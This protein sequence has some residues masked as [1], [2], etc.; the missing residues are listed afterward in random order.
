MSPE[1]PGPGDATLIHPPRELYPTLD[2]TREPVD[3]ALFQ[4]LPLDLMLR[5]HF[6]PV[7]EKEGVLWIA[8][9]D[10]L[11]IHAQDLLRMQLKRPLKICGAPQAQIQEVLKKSESGQKVLDEA[12]EAL[13]VQVLREEDLDEEVLDLERLTDKDE[14]PIIRLVDTTIFNALQRRASDIHMET[15]GAGFQIKYRID[16]SLYPAADP[17]DKRFASPIV[18]RIKVMSEL[19]IAEKRKPQDGRFTLKVRGRAIDFRVSIMPTIHGEDAVIRILDKENLSEEFSKLSLDILGF[20]Q[21]EL[22]KLRRFAKEPYGMFLVTGPTGSGKT[23]T[24]YAILSEIRNPEDKIITIE[25]PVEYQLEGVTQIPVNE[26]KGL[27]FALG[28]RSILR[29]DPD[30][31]LVGEIRDPETAQI[32]IQSALT[33][34]LVFTTVHANN[35]FDVLGRF[36]H[37]GVPIHNFVSALNCVLAQR[38]VKV[39]CP[40]CKKPHTPSAQEL[41]ENGMDLAWARSGTFFEK[42]G[43][44]DCQGNGFRGRQAIIEFLG[45]N[46][47]M[48]ELM[49]AQAG[50]REV[51]AAARRAGMQSLRESAL[52]KVR[53][54]MTTFAEINKVTFRE[55][56]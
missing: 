45:M 26:K 15:T 8:M 4:A 48:R 5:L 29:H 51:K 43:C 54:G 56:A 17:I 16:G 31:I 12:G 22:T 34:H 35:V 36:E 18:S 50:L 10:P 52:E 32:A 28:L 55:G 27:T 53:L 46:D 42:V 21:H 7:Q 44:V 6:V 40:K 24:L 2:L 9:A 23:T 11:D 13:K 14:A 25:D 47:E 19:D 1:M 37:M 30:K 38:L 49:T 20:S 39:L 3:F 41:E 33:G